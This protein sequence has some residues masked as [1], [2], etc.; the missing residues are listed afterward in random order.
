[1]WSLFSFAASETSYRFFC[2]VCD[3]RF[4]LCFSAEVGDATRMSFNSPTL[5]IAGNTLAPNTKYTFELHASGTRRF[6]FSCATARLTS[7]RLD[8]L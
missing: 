6:W 3:V 1:L 8:S 7:L 4:I 2:A 5:V